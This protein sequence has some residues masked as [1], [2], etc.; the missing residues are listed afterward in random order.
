MNE[1]NKSIKKIIWYLLFS[2]IFYIA[3]FILNRLTLFIS[4]DYTYHYVYKGYLPTKNIERVSGF[5]SI[6]RSQ[7][8]HWN[9]WNGRFVAHSIVQFFLQY[10]KIYFDVFNSAAFIVLNIIMMMFSKKNLKTS[11]PPI[12]YFLGFLFLW[13]YL[14]EIGK[15]I[16]WVSGSGNYLWTS[17]IYL[18]YFYLGTSLVTQKSKKID[19]IILIIL[20]FLSG[21]CNENSS[22]TILL[23][24]FLYMLTIYFLEKKWNWTVFFSLCSGGIGFILMMMSPGS[25]ARGTANL[26]P[27]FIKDNFLRIFDFLFQKYLPI[28]VVII[29]MFIAIILLK[30]KVS[31]QSKL[32]CLL[33]IFGHFISAMVMSVSPEI[34]DRTFFCSCIFLGIVLFTLFNILSKELNKKIIGFLFIIVSIFFVRSYY[35]VYQDLN[36]TYKQVS[37]QYQILYSTPPNTTI[38]L[39]V[40]TPPK[41]LYNAYNGTMNVGDDEKGWFNQWM[42]AYFN[43]KSIKGYVDP[44]MEKLNDN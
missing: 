13:F 6:I 12:T 43:K 25:R 37:Y 35:T 21:A 40:I 20:G 11:I 7:I 31:K 1:K 24:L 3:M 36:K 2:I 34:P 26:E 14:P 18:T 39:P 27:Q 4:D 22:P 8:G 29:I 33:L 44:G 10:K 32:L 5:V 28:Y 16:L 41:T 9:L 19:N 30:I 23:I 17:L 15:T 38:D 42:A